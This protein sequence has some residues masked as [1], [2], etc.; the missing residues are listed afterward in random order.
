[1]I[2]QH[3]VSWNRDKFGD[4]VVTT[5]NNPLCHINLSNC[6]ISCGIHPDMVWDSIISSYASF[7]DCEVRWT[8]AEKLNIFNANNC[9]IIGRLN[10]NNSVSPYIV[11][12]NCDLTAWS[13]QGV[14]K[15][16]MFYACEVHRLT[17][18]QAVLVACNVSGTKGIFNPGE[19]LRDNLEWSEEHNGYICY[20]NVGHTFYP[21]PIYWKIAPGEYLEEEIDRDITNHCG[22]GVN[23]ATREWCEKNRLGDDSYLWEC[24]VEAKDLPNVVVPV[25]TGG[26][27]RA[28]RVKLLSIILGPDYGY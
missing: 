12:Q 24:V 4:V 1:M 27:F 15:N 22:C 17:F 14:I 10:A 16:A 28:C 7:K 11:F 21:A 19:W 26:K 5:I 18:Y 2:S 3:Q 20:K 23:V 6:I 13:A 25:N 9:K 8:A